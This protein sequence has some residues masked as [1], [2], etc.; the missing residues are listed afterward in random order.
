MFPAHE[1]AV[2]FDVIVVSF[3][4]G[5]ADKP[6]LCRIAL[7]RLGFVGD[8]SAALLIDDRN[9]LVHAWQQV[10]GAGY[11]FRSDEQFRRDIPSPSR[12]TART[13]MTPDEPGA[14]G[15]RHAGRPSRVTGSGRDGRAAR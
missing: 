10:G 5:T 13:G 15:D 6:S 1:L 4:E 12:P 8:R 2:V 3:A 11:W 9:D 7:D 14:T